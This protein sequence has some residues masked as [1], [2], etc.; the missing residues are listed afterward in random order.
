MF[1]DWKECLMRHVV[2]VTGHRLPWD[3]ILY[4]SG[5]FMYLDQ[6]LSFLFILCYPS[7]LYPALT[8]ASDKT[9]NKAT[10]NY[11]FSG[12]SGKWHRGR[13]LTTFEMR[14]SQSYANGY[15]NKITNLYDWL[16]WI[17]QTLCCGLSHKIITLTSFFPTC[18]YQVI[19]NCMYYYKEIS[20]SLV[21]SLVLL[22]IKKLIAQW[23]WWHL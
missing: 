12:S 21:L 4:S 2:S 8:L 13:L 23:S 7:T 15:D 22:Q 16:Q 19:F 14:F 5:T 3:Y 18:V 20:H 11:F 17:P 1:M 6:Y 9:S 10:G